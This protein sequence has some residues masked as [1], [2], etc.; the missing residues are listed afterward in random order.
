VC[1]VLGIE[2]PFAPN[3]IAVVTSLPSCVFV[4]YNQYM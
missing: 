1:S 2:A 3:P 4:R